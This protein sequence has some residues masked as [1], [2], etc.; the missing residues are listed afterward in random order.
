[1][2]IARFLDRA[3]EPDRRLAV[4]NRS[5]PEPVQKL[6]ERLFEDQPVGIEEA[7]VPETDE[8][9]VVLLEDE[10]VVETSTL[11]EL[12][13]AILLVNSDVFVTGSRGIDELELPPV[14]EALE[15][16]N[17]SLRGY[18]Q[19]HREKMLFILLSRYIER[20]AYERGAG[21][22]RS[23]FQRLSR[24]VDERGT[25]DVYRRLADT[26]LDVHVYG[27]PNWTPDT[28]FGVTIHGGHT[29]DFTDTWFVVYTPPGSKADPLSGGRD[30]SD[31]A[32]REPDGP[33]AALLAYQTGSNEWNG[34][35]TF[36][37]SLVT[38]INRYVAYNL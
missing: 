2:S 33:F 23:S 32:V 21:T 10:T 19:S 6:L 12:E 36:D 20:L 17:F 7:D 35:W 18:P 9:V 24:L 5:R 37:R 30:G 3:G 14:L 13:E 8:D 27:V 16:V 31:S 38:D 34:Y 28:E 15:E 26:G 25:R 22:I 4:V 29:A 11:A 1:M